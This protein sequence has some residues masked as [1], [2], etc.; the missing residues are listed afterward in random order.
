MVAV[1]RLTAEDKSGSVACEVLST[2][3]SA[4]PVAK[5]S[6][7]APSL[8]VAEPNMLFLDGLQSAF[9]FAHEAK[10]FERVEK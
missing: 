8:V 3:P 1:E 7:T 4:R 5:E 10:R 6:K 2:P 9:D